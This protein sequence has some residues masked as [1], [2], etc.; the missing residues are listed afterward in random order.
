LNY[1]L[2]ISMKQVVKVQWT[3]MNHFTHFNKNWWK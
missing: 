3:W 2:L 1:L